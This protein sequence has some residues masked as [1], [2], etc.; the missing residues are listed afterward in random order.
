MSTADAVVVLGAEVLGPGRPSAAVRRR[1]AH[2]VEVLAKR[3]CDT[4]VVAGGVGR[5]GVS[6]ASVMRLLALGMGVPAE[7]VV[8]EETSH[9]TLEQAACV[10][11]LARERG[12][13]LLVLVTDRFHLPRALY[14]FRK[15]GIE[16]EGDP[17]AGRGKSSLCRWWAACFREAGAWARVAWR[18]VTGEQR[19]LAGIAAGPGRPAPPSAGGDGPAGD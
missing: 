13:R 12:W 3:G 18:V 14:L 1:L 11:S 17:T 4:L 5:G 2:G 6:E 10:A 19:R 9:N 7:S 8:M 15:M 16:V